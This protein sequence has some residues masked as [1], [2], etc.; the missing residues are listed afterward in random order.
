MSLRARH[1]LVLFTD[2]VSIWLLGPVESR[3]QDE[4]Y[5]HL[6]LKKLGPSRFLGHWEDIISY[7]NNFND[8]WSKLVVR[9]YFDQ[10]RKQMLRNVAFLDTVTTKQVPEFE[11]QKMRLS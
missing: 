7:L 5:Y 9:K 3:D 2:K 1:H 4:S 6:Q 8:F 11:N 10:W